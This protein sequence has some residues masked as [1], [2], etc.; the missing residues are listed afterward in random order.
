M[1]G[2]DGVVGWD[3]VGWSGSQVA[4]IHPPPL[5][6]QLYPIPPYHRSAATTITQAATMAGCS[7]A[8][9]PAAGLSIIQLLSYR[10]SLECLKYIAYGRSGLPS[11]SYC[12]RETST[13]AKHCVLATLSACLL[14]DAHYSLLTAHDWLL[15]THYSLFTVH[16]SLPTAHASLL[17]DHCSLLTFHCSLHTAHC[18][19]STANCSQFTANCTLPTAHCPLLSSHC[20]LLNANRPLP[21]AHCSRPTAR[22]S[23]RTP[24]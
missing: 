19:L 22:Y 11:T 9:C 4:N 10:R 17:T 1:A 13:T 5:R 2:W 24:D 3:G 12:Q 14:F 21:N 18:S 15:T 23:L 8:A 7:L 6:I 16:C 20:S